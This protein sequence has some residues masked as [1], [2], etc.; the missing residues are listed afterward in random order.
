MAVA[1]TPVEA[2]EV[3]VYATVYLTYAIE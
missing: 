2:G 3:T 1:E